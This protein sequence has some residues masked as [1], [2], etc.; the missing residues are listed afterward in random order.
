MKL[1]YLRHFFLTLVCLLSATVLYGQSPA[2][3]TGGT[4]N[5]ADYSRDVA[6][7][8]IIA[9]FGSNL[10][11]SSVPASVF[12]LPQSLGGASVELMPSGAQLP[13]FYASPGQINA[14]LPYDVPIGQLQLR[15][16]T[17]AGISN[18]D[19]LVVSRSAPKLFTID[20]S[21]KGHAVAV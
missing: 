12:P 19:T 14:Q 2:I 7:G 16:R 11:A 6:P 8:A 13:L 5:A 10:A 9:I 3:A 15:V 1:N 20:F 18:A 21:G 4:V 17:A